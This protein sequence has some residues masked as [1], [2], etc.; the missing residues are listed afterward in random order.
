MGRL[1]FWGWLGN[2]LF[3]V[4][5]NEMIVDFMTCGAVLNALPLVH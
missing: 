2:K 4:G 1:G 3:G 5:L